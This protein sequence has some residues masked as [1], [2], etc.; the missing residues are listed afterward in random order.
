V[1][2]D[3]EDF[4]ADRR[5]EPSDIVKDLRNN[6]QEYINSLQFEFKLANRLSKYIDDLAAAIDGRATAG[7]G[8]ATAHRNTLGTSIVD[9]QML[10]FSLRNTNKH[11]EVYMVKYK[12]DNS[13]MLTVAKRI[14][15]D[16]DVK[17]QTPNPV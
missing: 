14:R 1:G 6:I 9:M 10:L 15:N 7:D 13:E 2:D 8:A 5:T 3:A 16:I 4:H 11:R 17:T 12:Q